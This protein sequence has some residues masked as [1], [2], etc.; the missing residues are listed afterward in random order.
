MARNRLPRKV[1]LLSKPEVDNLRQRNMR[2]DCTLGLHAHISLSEAA[3]L[4]LTGDLEIIPHYLAPYGTFARRKAGTELK[5]SPATIKRSEME[6][7]A[8]TAFKGSRSRTARM[9]DWEKERAE[10]EGGLV[11][12]FIERAQAKVRLWPVIG[13]ERAPRV[14]PHGATHVRKIAL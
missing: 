7:N 14:A 5:Q 2:P 3:D 1:C 12:D 6:A 11:E 9:S 13:D 8:H 10:R 4:R